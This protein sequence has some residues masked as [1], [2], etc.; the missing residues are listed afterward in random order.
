MDY[1][2]YVTCQ[3]VVTESKYEK[4][5]EVMNLKWIPFILA[6][7]GIWWDWVF[8][9]KKKNYGKVRT[10]KARLVFKDFNKINCVDYNESFSPI[11]IC[12]GFYLSSLHTMIMKYDI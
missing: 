2:E 11:T 12:I 6:K 9:K 10:Y 3:E 8:K 1:D 4:L 5:I 7:Y